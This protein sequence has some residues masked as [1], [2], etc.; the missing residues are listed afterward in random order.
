MKKVLLML[1]IFLCVFSVL[2]V[3]PGATQEENL[4]EKF[5]NAISL[6]DSFLGYNESYMVFHTNLLLYPMDDIT[7]WGNIVKKVVSAEEYESTLHKYF[8]IDDAMLQKI[9]TNVPHWAE[10]NSENQTY[11]IE[12]VGG[13]GFTN[14][15]ERRYSH[16]IE[17][18][19]DTYDVFYEHVTYG[20]LSD[21]LP[22]G[23][24]E[25]DY[26]EL[27]GY[28]D[29]LVYKE[30]E[31]YLTVDGYMSIDFDGYG[32]KYNVELN[33]DIVRILSCTE[34]SKNSSGEFE[35]GSGTESDPYYITTKEHLNN[36][37]NYPNAH[38]KLAN[39]IVFYD[40]DY[41]EGGEYYNSGKGWEPI[42]S[43]SGNAFNGVFDGNGYVI[44]NIYVNIKNDAGDIYAGIFGYNKGTIKNL[45]NDNGTVLS[46]SEVYD[47]DAHSGGIVGYNNGGEI[48]NCFN[49]GKVSAVYNYAGGIAGYS[50]GGKIIKCYNTGKVESAPSG[51]FYS[52][53][54]QAAGIVASGSADIIYCYNT[55]D[56]ETYGFYAAGISVQAN[57]VKC[58]YNTGKICAKRLNSGI[59]LQGKVSDCYNTGDISKWYDGCWEQPFGLTA[60]ND[61]I[62]GDEI[63]NCYNIGK[64]WGD[65]YGAIV[66]IDEYEEKEINN[67][68]YLGYSEYNQYLTDAKYTTKCTK[69]QLADKN[70][71]SGFD[72]ENVWTI[73]ST[74]DYKY[75]T[76]RMGDIEE[77]PS[78]PEVEPESPNVV[79]IEMK[80]YPYKTV[81]IY[82]ETLDLRG[83]KIYVF[84][85]DGTLESVGLSEC[86]VEYDEQAAGTVDVSVY[87]LGYNTKF[88]ITVRNIIDE[89]VFQ[90]PETTN[91]FLGETLDLSSG[92]I[93]T[94]YRNGDWEYVNLTP[95]MVSGFDNTK[96]GVQTLTV[97]YSGICWKF[98]VEVCER[99]DDPEDLAPKS[100]R[101]IFISDDYSIGDGS[102]KD[103]NNPLRPM[104]H[105]A[106]DPEAEYP[107]NHLQTPFYQAT[108]LLKNTGGTIV[109]CGP[110]H[111]GIDESYGSGNSTRDVF[112]AKFGANVIKFTSVYD[113]VDY[114]ET[115]GAKIT[116]D[117]PAEIGV[118]G[119]SIWENLD[120][121]TKGTNRVISFGGYTTLVG[122]GIK[123]YPFDEA[124]T[125]VASNYISLSS[126]HRYA[127]GVDTTLYLKVKSGTYNTIAAGMWGVNNVRRYN[128]AYNPESGIKSTNNLD[129]N[130]VA[131]LIIDG[132][133]TVYGSIIGTNK[134]MAEFS[135]ETY[136]TINGGT[137]ECDIFAIGKTGMLN[138][139]G[140][141]IV[142]IN[143]GDFKGMWSINAIE[144]PH[145]NNAPAYS[146]LDFSDWKG[147]LKDLAYAYSVTDITEEKFTEIRL[148]DGITP[149]M[150]MRELEGLSYIGDLSGDM[151]VDSDD[152]VYLLYSVLFGSESYPLNQV[153]DYDSNGI[154]DSDDAVYLLYHVLFG[155][156]NYPLN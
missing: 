93:Y 26:A 137:F 114:R 41:D 120:I 123:C 19:D 134:Q 87:Y 70:T 133:T 99:I 85:D 140:Q 127:G 142:K 25:Y 101:V 136:I 128:E 149:E 150:L 115:D 66:Y 35:Y 100:D 152:A 55:A 49:T 76:L 38:F 146:L 52:T 131:K 139:D 107:K 22:D 151:V 113:G 83:G 57:T 130:T 141:A 48:N 144:I 8:K 45:G 110:V 98:D 53:S 97:E 92:K 86:I 54:D 154:T 51:M 13:R 106:F 74:S 95:D 72:F 73:D 124:F 12:F 156:D 155:A 30:V 135:G 11:A 94:Y 77:K 78:T 34:Y 143:G 121:E 91:Y 36:V 18:C 7:D 42:G 105:D 90:K 6:A 50:N 23:M 116:I 62:G 59:A 69:E 10:Y 89:I 63:T 132:T 21:V 112:T 82:G 68:Y 17:N 61:G 20:S 29:P 117:T 126:G 64:V 119:S 125:G 43:S 122:E 75:P 109:I 65:R 40:S 16:Y 102:G 67:C 60:C 2:T 147:S 108:E 138:T 3:S 15:L 84:Y 46:E 39:D 104:D 24:S 81:Y 5:Q 103:A 37:R 71:F 56:I 9:R 118:Y 14:M 1:L 88:E 33:G 129:G 28:T 153:A 80:A 31:Y 27:Q 96:L 58:C 79:K 44:K 4:D 47:Y 111:F 148:P 145:T 32:N